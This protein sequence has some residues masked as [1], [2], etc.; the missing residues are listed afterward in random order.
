[1]W[2]TDYVLDYTDAAQT[3]DGSTRTWTYSSQ[4]GIT[5]TNT[6]ANLD[7]ASITAPSGSGTVTGIKY[8]ASAQYTIH[9]PS[10]ISIRSIKFYGRDNYADT[11][12]FL[13]ELN[14]TSYDPGLYTFT[15]DKALL[16]YSFNITPSA[17]GD[18]GAHKITFTPSGT[19]VVWYITLSTETVD[20]S[21]PIV[22]STS[23]PFVISQSTLTNGSSSTWAF[24]NSFTVTGHDSG[25]GT[26]Y[27]RFN[28][29]KWTKD[30]EYT[31]N[32]PTGKYVYKVKFWG[33]SNVKT[34]GT[35]AKS[36]LSSLSD[37]SSSF[38]G[39]ELPYSDKVKSAGPPITYEDIASS[40]CGEHTFILDHPVTGTIS[41]TFTNQQTCAIVTLYTCEYLQEDATSYTPT[42]ATGVDVVLKRTLSKDYYNSICLPF[43]V[44]LTKSAGN[45]LYGAS[46]QKFNAVDGTTLK[47]TAETTTMTAG[48]PYLVKPTSTLTNPVFTGVDV[49]AVAAST[50]TINNGTYD[51]NFK[52]TYTKVNLATD[53]TEQFLNTSGSL[54]YPSSAGTATMKGLRAYFIVNSEIL[55]AQTARTLSISFDDNETTGIKDAVKNEE[56]GM[57]NY[58]D[59]QGRKVAQPTKGLYI[60]NGKKVVIK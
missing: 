53:R 32:I 41:F 5:I 47:F 6:A 60:V 50:V 17:E 8:K 52:G 36:I 42:A 7:G 18:A 39:T 46:V 16:T 49:K 26:S 58:F 24:Q 20:P 34:T 11:D 15:K 38:T 21:G 31:I 9:I 55:Q 59:L 23:S 54:S 19:Q 29:I 56:S 10:G 48:T 35:P 25:F 22:P 4:G 30:R 43:D 3:I 27:G 12:A 33:Y 13:S 14:A 28:T 57:K 51:F 40:D 1:M 2:A 37:Y 44:D 45:P